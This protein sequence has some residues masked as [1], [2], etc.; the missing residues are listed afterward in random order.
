LGQWVRKI[1]IREYGTGNAGASNVTSTMG[2]KYGIVV[3]AFDIFKG[4]LAVGAV[5]AIFPGTPELAY[6]AGLMAV[7]GHLFPFYLRF[8]GGKGVAALV[9]MM[10]GVDWRLGIL[11]VLLVAVPALAADY[12]VVGSLTVFIL[13]PVV[14][15]LAGYSTA[16]IAGGIILT[17]LSFYLHWGNLRRINRGE[18]L[19]ISS[20]LKNNG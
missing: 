7:V 14:T 13:L 2:L 19:K 8:R 5:R 10:F 16:L 17:G 11:F 3:G 1:D 9:G 20:V 18:E 15:Y 12:I 4:A 6:L